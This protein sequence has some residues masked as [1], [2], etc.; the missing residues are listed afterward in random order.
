MQIEKP[1]LFPAPEFSAP[2]DLGHLQRLL[3]ILPDKPLIQALN[4]THKGG[5][6]T[7]GFDAHVL[8]R[9]LVAGIFFRHRYV[10]GILAELLRNAPLRDVCGLGLKPVPKDYQM[11]RFMGRLVKQQAALEQMFA[12]LVQLLKAHLPDFGQNLAQDSTHLRT[13]ARG[14]RGD[15]AE[16]SADPEAAF[17]VKVKRRKRPDGTPYESVMKWFGYKLHLLIDSKYELPLAFTVTAANKDDAKELP[18]CV[19]Q[20][21]KTLA[22][23]VPEE[24]RASIFAG[25]PLAA[26]KAYDETENYRMLGE[27]YGIKPV[28]DMQHAQADQGT[29]Y[30]RDR[31]TR[32]RNEKTGAFHEMRF[33][34]YEKS[35]KALKYGCPCH[36]HGECPFFGARCNRAVG[37]A[38]LILRIK[39]EDNYRYYTAIPRE[40]KKWKREYRK[41]TAVERVNGRL[42]QV[43]DLE[44][45]GFRGRKKVTARATM[46]LLIMLAHA[47][48]AIEQKRPNEVRSMRGSVQDPAA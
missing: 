17:G 24:Q 15:P 20:A 39:L 9:I 45:T 26:D 34:G 41:R 29:V 31:D 13:N 46:G 16:P 23:T 37:G 38:G 11:S 33:L 22:P 12:T 47:L 40:S 36:G 10:A 19:A 5:G 18:V 43:L 14:K 28:I 1:S 2:S 42:K 48:Q 35:R 32:V 7:P 21:Q 3:D 8:W 30:D 25:A 6:R 4:A 27:D 44:Y